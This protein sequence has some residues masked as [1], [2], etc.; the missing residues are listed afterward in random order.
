MF[1]NCRPHVA[2]SRQHSAEL[3]TTSWLAQTV[4]RLPAV[5]KIWVRSLGWEDSPE[6][7]MPTTPVLLPGKSPG[8]RS[9]V[10]YSPWGRKAWDTTERLHFH[11]LTFHFSHGKESACSAGD[12]DSTPGLGRSLG[13]GNGIPLQYSSLGNFADRAAGGATVHGLEESERTKRLTLSPFTFSP[14]D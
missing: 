4:K 13:E 12:L 5:R 10:G 8:W 3:V 1:I 7:E 11:F 14:S 9:L 2:I 6:K